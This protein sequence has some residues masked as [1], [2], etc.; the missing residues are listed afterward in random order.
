[1]E[2]LEGKKFV[3]TGG[4]RGLGLGIVEAL[5]EQK[6]RVTVIARDQSRLDDVKKRLGVDV[7]RGDVADE[8]LARSVIGDLRPSGV[9][10]NAGAQAVM[11]PIHELEWEDFSKIWNTDVKAGFHWVQAALRLPLSPGSRVILG[12]S[13]AAIQGSPLSGGYAGAKRMLWLMASY[14]NG[15]AKELGLGIHFQAILPMQINAD[16]ELGRAAAEAYARKKGVS[17]E[18]FSAAFGAPLPARKVGDH[19]VSLLTD[20][21]YETGVSFGLKGEPGI[22]PLDG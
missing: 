5:V 16:T 4:S 22:V 3:V 21:K 12:S 18:A 10:L 14:A 11:G 2:T 19:V 7:I 6:A 17:L 8:N 20:P 15:V 1:M 9:V 13:G